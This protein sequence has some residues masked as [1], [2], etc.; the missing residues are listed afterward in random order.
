MWLRWSLRDLRQRWA[1]VVAIALVIAIGI[2]VYAGLGSTSTW[3]RLSNDGSFAALGMHDLRADAEPGHVRRQGRSPRSPRASRDA[4]AITAARERL[5]VDSQIDASAPGRPVLTAAR[6]VGMDMDARPVVTAAPE[7]ATA[8]AAARRRVPQAVLEG[9]FAEHCGPARPRAG[10]P[11][12]RRAGAATRASAPSPRTSSYEG[13]EGSVLGTGELAPRSTCRSPPRRRSPDR[14]GQVNDVVLR[15]DGGRRSRPSS[16]AAADRGPRRARDRGDRLR[17]RTEAYAVRVLY[18]DIENDQLFWNVLAGLVLAAAALAAFNLISRIVEAQRREIGI[19]MA[20]GVA[21]HGSPCVPCSSACRWPCSARSAGH[22]RRIACRGERC[23]TCCESLLPLPVYRTPFQS[24][25]YGRA[26]A[27]RARD[28]A[29][30]QRDPG[31]AG[32][33]ASSR[34]R[35]SAPG[36]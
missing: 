7:C 11:R 26:A 22:R 2:G 34:S 32:A 15:L 3:R 30:R 14:P 27:A 13:P 1:A 31:L 10:D 35:R 33:C 36:T 21:A 9:V 12:R 29:D 19:G 23:A 20:L 8:D 18:E 25:V 16:E 6:L 5:I 28:T 24:G 4:D 17:P